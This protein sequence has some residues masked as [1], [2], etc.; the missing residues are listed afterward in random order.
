[1]NYARM[2]IEKEAPEEYGY[3]RIRYNLSESSIADQKLSDIG[4]ALPDLT[5]FYGEHRGDKELRALIAAQDE[6][7]SPNDVLVTAGAAG[8]LFIIATALLSAGDHLVVVRP[9]YATNIE[10]PKAI[11]CAISYVDLDFDQ[12]FAVDIERVK[13]GMRQ[14]TRLISVTCPHNP[15]GTMM[16]R[17]DLDALIALAERHRCRLL[18]DETYRDLSYGTRL[19]S[20]ASLSPGAISVCSLS[21][22]F[23]IPGIRVGW[24][25]TRD[26]ELQETFLA[27]KEQIGICGSVIDEA[28][29]RTMLERRDVFLASL[30]PEMARRRDIVQTWIDG[31]PMVDWVRPQGGVVG[32]PRL[33]V[34]AGFDLDNFY[35]RLREKH[36]TYVGPG[37]WFEM[38]KRFFRIGFGWPKEAELRGGLEAVS[39]AL[40]D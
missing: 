16:T 22:A 17:G 3:D 33:N 40:R 34:D 19:P 28:I 14:N 7:L 6:G 26:P 1:M 39:A 37:H 20:A 35:S 38:P 36:G 8:A 11:G 23:G 13:A 32:F 30:L 9:N 15:T 5:L 18:V 24:L 10:T 27:A 4:L 29:A 21:K 25:V 12:G 2:V 31:E